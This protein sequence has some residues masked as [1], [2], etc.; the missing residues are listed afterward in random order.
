MSAASRPGVRESLKALEG[1]AEY[2]YGRDHAITRACRA[3]DVNAFLAATRFVTQSTDIRLAN[4][5][6]RISLEERQ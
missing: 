3:G 2:N 6:D 5:Q 4:M 1:Y